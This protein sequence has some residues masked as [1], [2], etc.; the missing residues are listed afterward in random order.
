MAK[1]YYLYDYC[2]FVLQFVVVCDTGDKQVT[3][4]H[5]SCGCDIIWAC[6][7]RGDMYM[8]VGSPYAIATDTFSP[9]WVQVEG[10]P[11]ANTIFLKVGKLEY[12]M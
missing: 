11:L 2:F 12:N 1:D 8:A 10:K 3:L 7:T 9:A 5:V 6:D 4:R